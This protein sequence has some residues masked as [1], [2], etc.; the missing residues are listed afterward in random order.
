MKTVVYNGSRE[1]YQN[2]VSAAKSLLTHTAVDK[3]FFLIE[4]DVFPYPLP[5][6]IETINVSGLVSQIFRPDGPNY[7][8]TWTPIG[9]IR[10]AL[11][12]VFPD[13][14][15]ILAIDADTIVMQDISDLWELSLDDC[16]FAAAKEPVLTQNRGYFYTNAGVMLINLKKLRED[17]KDNEIISALNKR[18][19]FFVGQDAA[20]LLCQGHIL[21][22]PSDYNACD[23]TLPAE[24]KKILHFAGRKEWVNGELARQYRE[25]PWPKP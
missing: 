24:N 8:S 9:L 3:I 23:F 2:M 13:F 14:D 21:E 15:T 4:D 19:F 6:I 5:P 22:I 1:I 7:R 11:T 18:H 12:K 10:W 17:G 16:Y 25:M 20:N